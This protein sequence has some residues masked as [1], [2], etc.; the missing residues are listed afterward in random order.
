MSDVQIQTTRL[1]PTANEALMALRLEVFASV[2]RKDIEATLRLF[3]A[4]EKAAAESPVTRS[5]A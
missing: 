3:E 5:K 1:D 2:P 4:I